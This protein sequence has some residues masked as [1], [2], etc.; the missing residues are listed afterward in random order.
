[1]LITGS[2][3]SAALTKNAGKFRV[4]IIFT[5][6]DQPVPKK[7][8]RYMY[9][10]HL[11][12]NKFLLLRISHLSPVKP[13]IQTQHNIPLY[14]IFHWWNLKCCKYLKPRK[15]WIRKILRELSKTNPS[16]WSLCRWY[17]WFWYCLS[18]NDFSISLGKW[19]I[20]WYAA[21]IISCSKS[22]LV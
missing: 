7:Y 15:L 3:K 5:S 20:V 8:H 13:G 19:P 21:L 9:W 1:M 17:S 16:C 6:I 2:Y 4:Y 14:Y 11:K 10:M 18:K 12:H 22:S